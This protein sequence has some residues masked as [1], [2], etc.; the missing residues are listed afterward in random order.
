MIHDLALS[1]VRSDDSL[2]IKNPVHSPD[3]A[4][5]VN[6]KKVQETPNKSVRPE[7]VEGQV[8]KLLDC[9][10]SVVK[11]VDANYDAG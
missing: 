7:S 3:H 10:L 2:V 1:P 11:S 9:V 5:N 4:I 6:M 8:Q